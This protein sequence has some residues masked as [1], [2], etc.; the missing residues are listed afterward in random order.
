MK[1]NKERVGLVLILIALLLNPLSNQFV[2]QG[3]DWALTEAS[4]YAGVWATIVA[5]VYTVGLMVWYNF[6]ASR[7]KIPHKG[8]ATKK[9]P[10]KYIET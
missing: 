6:Q 7:I 4:K 8:K 5:G 1:L 9:L 10:S 2:Q 3:L